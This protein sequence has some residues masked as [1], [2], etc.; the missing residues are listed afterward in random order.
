V[1]GPRGPGRDRTIGHPSGVV[2]RRGA[3]GSTER[4]R[5]KGEIETQ[6]KKAHDRRRSVIPPVGG[7]DRLGLE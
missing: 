6:K 3:Q 5:V 2:E 7:G 4:I 1:T